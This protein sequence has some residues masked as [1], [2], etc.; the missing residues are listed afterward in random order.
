MRRRRSSLL[1]GIDPSNVLSPEDSGEICT[2]RSSLRLRRKSMQFKVPA[3]ITFDYGDENQPQCCL[4]SNTESCT[5]PVS[6][7]TQP[8]PSV[9]INSPSASHLPVQPSDDH[10]NSPTLMNGISSVGDITSLPVP[11]SSGDLK[12]H[13]RDHPDWLKIR[14]SPP[15]L[16]G[17]DA[18]PEGRSLQLRPNNARRLTAPPSNILRLQ[19]FTGQTLDEACLPHCPGGTRLDPTLVLNISKRRVR[20]RQLKAKRMG[21][22]GI[23]MS[24]QTER[25]MARFYRLSQNLSSTSPS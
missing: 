1:A 3:V 5:Y 15:K 16:Q 19:V 25:R 13:F 7:S 23:H 4:Q 22:R 2:R 11:T 9:Q 17:L 20:S 18:I 21:F 10:P 12:T 14:Y 24:A 6:P 8:F